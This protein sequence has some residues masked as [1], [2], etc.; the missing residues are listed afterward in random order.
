RPAAAA[1]GPAP[2]AGR[3]GAGSGCPQ[4]RRAVAAAAPQPTVAVASGSTNRASITWL[5]SRSL[6]LPAT[7]V[8]GRPGGPPAPIA[9]TVSAPYRYRPRPA[10]TAARRATRRPATALPA[11]SVPPAP[12]TA[13][14][15][16]TSS[17]SAPGMVIGPR[18]RP[19]P[20]PETASQAAATNRPPASP[21]PATPGRRSREPPASR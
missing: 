17:G 19:K 9:A 20:H 5:P 7:V 21:G 8:C 16:I 12:T 2:A 18:N 14:T 4:R 15:T 10:D 13:G 6:T 3:A 11:H 1:A